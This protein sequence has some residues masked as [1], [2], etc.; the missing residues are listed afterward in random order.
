MVMTISKFVFLLLFQFSLV[1]DQSLE[2]PKASPRIKSQQKNKSFKRPT[3]ANIILK[4]T[5]GGQTWQDIS[6]GLP[7]NLQADSFI[8]KDSEL[9]IRAGNGI[10]HN[11]PNSKAPFWRKEIYPDQPS[12]IAPGS[13]AIFAYNYGGQFLQRINGTSLWLPMLTN[14]PTRQARTVFE[15]G[16]TVFIGCD[17]GLFKSTDGGKIWRQVYTGGRVMKLVAADGVLMATSQSGILR[18]ADD[19]ENWDNV[20]N[21]GGIGIAIERI[22]G[23]FAAITYNTASETRRVRVSYDGG[24]IWQPIDGGLPASLSIA[25][26]IQFGEYFLCG[27]PTGIFRSSDKGKTWTLLLPSIESKVFDLSVSGNVIYAMPKNGGC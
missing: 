3:A 11:K 10:Y 20:I 22:K 16:S 1:F 21:E 24:K 5:D 25:S 23:G 6:E 19:G 17:S 18:S 7:E 4:S 26:I 14:L 12:S 8:E 27:H 9:Y 13:T 2:S 15:N